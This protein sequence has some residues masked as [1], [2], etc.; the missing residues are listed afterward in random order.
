MENNENHTPA[1]GKPQFSLD[2]ERRIKTLSPGALTAKRF[3]RNKLAVVGIAILAVMFTFS[4]IGPLL[5]RIQ[6]MIKVIWDFRDQYNICPACYTGMESNPAY[7][8]SH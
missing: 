6:N 8:M 3:F 1:S 5:D 7:F 2:D 4:F